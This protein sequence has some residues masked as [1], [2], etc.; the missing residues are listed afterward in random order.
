VPA[1]RLGAEGEREETSVSERRQGAAEGQRV[2]EFLFAGAKAPQRV[3]RTFAASGPGSWMFARVLHH[4]DKPIGRMTGGRRTLASLLSGLPVVFLTTTGA[5]S[6][7]PRTV[8]VL[9]L[10]T[11]DGLAVIASNYGQVRHPGWYHN[12]LA[13]PTGQVAVGGVTRRFRATIAKGETRERIWQQGLRIYPGW[14]Q[15]ERRASHRKITI[16]VLGDA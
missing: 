12:L 5:R 4:I 7:K 10:P 14:S 3:M 9:G 15:Y 16:F 13:D 6:G 8:P 11:A 2:D 1:I